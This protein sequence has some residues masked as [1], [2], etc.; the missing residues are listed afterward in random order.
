MGNGKRILNATIVAMIAFDTWLTCIWL[1]RSQPTPSMAKP[2]AEATSSTSA[3]IGDIFTDPMTHPS[4]A[5]LDW[6]PVLQNIP[7]AQP[8][9]TC[10]S[11]D[12]EK[13]DF[14]GGSNTAVLWNN[15]NAVNKN[16]SYH[17]TTRATSAASQ[18]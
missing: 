13:W 11:S 5:Q 9:F 10:T 15:W 3:V 7:G 14:G 1:F 2:S 16:L 17:Y 18:P 8:V 12:A 6:P 4:T